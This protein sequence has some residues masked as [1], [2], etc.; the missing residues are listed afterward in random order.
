MSTKTYI[1]GNYAMATTTPPVKVATGTSTLTLL[2]LKTGVRPIDIIEWGI[3]FD[4]STAAAPGQVELV[5]SNVAATVSAHIAAGVQ[6][7]NDPNAPPST[8]SLGTAATGFTATAEGTTTVTRSLDTQLIAPTG[9]YVKQFPLGYEPEIA[10]NGAFLRVR[11]T[12][13]VT[14]NATCYIIYTEG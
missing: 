11:V 6:P 10:Y 3:S 8:L 4:G 14:V 5:Q 9:Q 12:F 1:V 13:A 7:H 2:Q